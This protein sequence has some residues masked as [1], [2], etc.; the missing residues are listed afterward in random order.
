MTTFFCYVE[1]CIVV[2]ADNEFDAEEE[3]R[4][5]LGEMLT[6]IDDQ[7]EIRVETDD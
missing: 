1:T 7:P 3:A 4:L 5:K 6:S 2:E